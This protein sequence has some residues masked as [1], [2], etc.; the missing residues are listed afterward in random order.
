M[1]IKHSSSLFKRKTI[2][3]RSFSRNVWRTNIDILIFAI[4]FLI[5]ALLQSTITFA[6]CKMY[7]I[8]KR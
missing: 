7:I 5:S 8:S 4:R 6:E 3:E 2:L 1:I